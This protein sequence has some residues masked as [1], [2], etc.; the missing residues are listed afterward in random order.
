MDPVRP[1]LAWALGR[2]GSRVP[3][4]GP[5]NTVAPVDVVSRWLR[6]LM[7]LPFEDPTF[8]LA[9]MQLARRTDDRYRDLSAKLRDKVVGWLE[10]Q[11]SPPHFVD[12]VRDE[13]AAKYPIVDIDGVRATF[14]HGWALVRASNT[15]GALVLRF[16]ADSDSELKTIKGEV[17]A[18]LERAIKSLA[19]PDTKE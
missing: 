17:D 11:D 5:L 9:V 6:S 3:V 10:R 4:Y 7:G 8:A 19:A 18:V 12:L 14:P 16:E 2:I 15:Q 1:A 13:L